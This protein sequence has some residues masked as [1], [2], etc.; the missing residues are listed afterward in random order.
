MELFENLITWWLSR[1]AAA[2]IGILFTLEA[3]LAGILYFLVSG[4]WTRDFI[5]RWCRIEP[6]MIMPIALMF[7][8][9]VGFLGA[10]I[11]QRNQQAGKSVADEARALDTIHALTRTSH[12]GLADVR[13]AAC[14]YATVVVEQ[15]FPQFGNVG[16]NPAAVAAV[17]ELERLAAE[18]AEDRD[19]PPVAAHGIM[20]SVIVLKKSREERSLLLHGNSEFEWLTVI[21][22]SLIL[23]TTIALGRTD[24][25]RMM[26]ATW[27]MFIPAVVIVLGLLA[28]RENPFSP[29]LS[30]SSAPLEAA[31]LHLSAP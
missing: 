15:E 25:P 23:I 11:R 14:R 17:D 21:T 9:L 31:G 3:G 10:D 22:L 2:V 18:Y 1:P 19:S 13:G 26:V 24:S 4:R 12:G 6:M 20:D 16:E 30:V 28:L 5:Q 29:P 8:L 7:G 27:A